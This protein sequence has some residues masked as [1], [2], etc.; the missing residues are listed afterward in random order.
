[1][2]NVS[3]PMII[4]T[5]TPRPARTDGSK[6]GRSPIRPPE[7]V[8]LARTSAAELVLADLFDPAV[9]EAGRLAVRIVAV[10]VAVPVA[11]LVAVLVAVPVSGRVVASARR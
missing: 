8:N 9:A 6:S 7:S 10:L 2:P 11:V 3:S 4:A 5:N 1:M